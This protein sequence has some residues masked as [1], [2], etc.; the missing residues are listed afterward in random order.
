MIQISDIKRANRIYFE[1]NNLEPLFDKIDEPTIAYLEKEQISHPFSSR[2]IILE[3]LNISLIIAKEIS[4]LPTLFQDYF[5]FDVFENIIKYDKTYI[6]KNSFKIV[7]D[8]YEDFYYLESEFQILSKDDSF[9]I[10]LLVD[11]TH[12]LETRL[13]INNFVDWINKEGSIYVTYWL[14]RVHKEL[15]V[16]IDLIE[17][18]EKNIIKAWELHDKQIKNLNNKILSRSYKKTITNNRI[19][20]YDYRIAIEYIAF[21]KKESVKYKLPLFDSTIN[22]HNTPKLDQTYKSSIRTSKSVMTVRK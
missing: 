3:I 10:E 12:F 8:I 20:M 13:T 7:R 14:T 9:L 17:L 6:K 4:K 15:N 5:E 18:N 22:N 2:K 19:K 1:F 21:M 16:H 11:D